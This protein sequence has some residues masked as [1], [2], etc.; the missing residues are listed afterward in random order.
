LDALV[1][2][3]QVN[4]VD[5]MKLYGSKYKSLHYFASI[6][7][8]G[9]ANS[10]CDEFHGGAGFAN[11]HLMLGNY[12][13]Q[14][15]QLVDPGVCLHYMDYSMYFEKHAFTQRKFAVLEFVICCSCD[16]LYV[17]IL[18]IRQMVAHGQKFLQKVGSAPMIRPLAEYWTA[19]GQICLYLV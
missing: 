18:R 9:G 6:H 17:Q 2:L 7:N 10:V 19:D 11:N 13:E 3:W 8:D 5:G 1:T 14:S 12:L 15:L 4:T 16:Y